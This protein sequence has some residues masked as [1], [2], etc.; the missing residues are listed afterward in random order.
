M[1]HWLTQKVNKENHEKDVA[2]TALVEPLGQKQ[3]SYDL[4][5]E[6]VETPLET[7][8]NN[9]LNLEE[10]IE[11]QIIQKDENVFINKECFNDPGFWP[12]LTDNIRTHIIEQKPY[13]L[14]VNHYFPLNADGRHF[15]GKWFF[16]SLPNGE[17]VRRQWLV[18]SISKDALFCF[19]CLLF[20]NKNKRKSP[21][22]DNGFSDWQHLN[23]RISEHE[24]S[25]FH[26]KCYVDW[27]EFEKRL[28][29][30]KTIDND[31]QKIIQYEKNKW[32]NILKTICNVI[33]F[34]AKN[35]LPLRGS[36]DK[37][38][39]NCGIFLG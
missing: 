37:G 26:Q 34:C 22:F 27:K 35:N 19:P 14:D 32:C 2:C 29:D 11:Q 23:P 30:G 33:L 15:D 17:N 13:H 7:T 9:A 36:S 28:K 24:L 39:D 38:D 4:K 5:L 10:N 1:A 18:Y 12:L 16:K 25:D 21:F 3:K 8:S 31:L 20:K 6:T